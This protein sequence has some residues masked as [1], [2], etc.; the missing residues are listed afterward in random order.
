ML[1]DEQK[2]LHLWWPLLQKLQDNYGPVGFCL[3]NDFYLLCVRIWG[4]WSFCHL[5]VSVTL[6]LTWFFVRSTYSFSCFEGY[7]I[8]EVTFFL[9]CYH[10]FHQNHFKNYVSY[11][12]ESIPV[13]HLITVN[14]VENFRFACFLFLKKGMKFRRKCNFFKM[15]FWLS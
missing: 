10:W 14:F 2:D 1:R 4:K 7:L 13:S 6:P 9:I 12:I 5:S 11:R 8:L 15:Y 3:E